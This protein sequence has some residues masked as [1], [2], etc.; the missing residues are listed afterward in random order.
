MEPAQL[1]IHPDSRVVVA[2][3]ANLGDAPWKI[4]NVESVAEPFGSE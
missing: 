1:I 3:L 4:A 2:L